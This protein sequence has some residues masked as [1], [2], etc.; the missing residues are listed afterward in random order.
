MQQY[1]DIDPVFTEPDLAI[2]AKRLPDQHN[3]D[4]PEIA[5]ALEA[6]TSS[7]IKQ[8]HSHITTHLN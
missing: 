4:A 7:A 8:I 2:I 6:I 1:L 3:L 5:R